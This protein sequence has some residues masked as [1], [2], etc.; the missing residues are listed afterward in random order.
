MLS[1][2][3]W[4]FRAGW[5]AKM[6]KITK[7][8]SHY[9]F[10]D[11]GCECYSEDDDDND[12]DVCRSYMK[13]TRR[14]DVLGTIMCTAAYCRREIKCV[15]ITSLVSQ[16]VMHTHTETFTVT[17]S[18]FRGKRTHIRNH[19]HL[20]KLA[21]LYVHT[22]SMIFKSRQINPQTNTHISECTCPHSSFIIALE[23]PLW[24][25][26]PAST[27]PQSNTHTWNTSRGQSLAMTTSLDTTH[28][29]Y[30]LDVYNWIAIPAAKT[31][32]LTEQKN[33]PH[34]PEFMQNML[35]AAG[36]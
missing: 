6:G 25:F 29:S 35:C 13:C 32:L 23:R 26:F 24:P 9:P 7:T 8:R 14:K 1:A 31:H 27:R 28:K 12:E 36:C 2:F 17:Q 18:E 34:F 5:Y 11:S 4:R 20:G 22:H 10:H 3:S 19:T 33:H 15:G 21:N 30:N 16:T